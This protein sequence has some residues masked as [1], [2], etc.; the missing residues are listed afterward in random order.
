VI[1]PRYLSEPGDLR[2]LMQGARQMRAL[3]QDATLRR[4]I[5][6]EMAPGDAV[7]DDAG[8]EA[9]IRARSSNAFHPVGTCRMGGDAEAVVDPRL[10]LRG[11]AGLRVAD[12]SV[13]PTMIN[14]NTNAA[15]MMIGEKAAA[16]IRADNGGRA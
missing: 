7:A 11:I 4:V 12:A 9:D 8:L 13:M 3:M 14:A 2:V 15:A 6:A 10:R 1:A 16:M 5:S